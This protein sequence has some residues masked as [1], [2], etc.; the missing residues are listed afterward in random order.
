[1]DNRDFQFGTHYR[2]LNVLTLLLVWR[3]LGRKWLV[4]H[5]LSVTEKDSFEKSLDAVFGS[6]CDRWILLSQWSGRWGKSTDKAFAEYVKDLST[7]W[8][9]ISLLA[10]PGQV[11]DVL[12]ARMDAWIEALQVDSVNYIDG[13]AVLT[14]DRV[15]DYYLP[16][17][18]WHRLDAHRW[19]ASKLPLRDSKRG[20]SLDVDHVVAV[21]LWDTL[22][23]AQQLIDS[24]DESRLGTDDLSTTMHAL[25][26]CCLLEKSFNIAKGSESFA[27]FLSRVHEF[28]SG[29][30]NV[31]DW[32]KSLGITET[33][34][35]P[36]GK[37]EEDIRRDV[38]AR[39]IA[40]KSDLKEYL[41][42]ARDRVDI[43][44]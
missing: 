24:E 40:M 3:L 26:N 25:G 11:I 33:L 34:V 38:E 30:K 35:D 28:R 43:K 8:S 39:T 22:P 9:K 15:H 31:R 42:G 1:M 16:L 10:T 29:T 37:S 2:S 5:P 21:K 44:T 41:T 4:M 36:T 27:K 6:Y 14:R 7:D 23:S 32:T 20:L 12:K 18:L 19:E 17:W 13:L